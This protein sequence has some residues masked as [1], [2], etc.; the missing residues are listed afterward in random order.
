M[1]LYE[2]LISQAPDI[3]CV[4]A[5]TK[6]R[7]KARWNNNA[8]IEDD[9]KDPD[10]GNA[11]PSVFEIITAWNQVK[12]EQVAAALVVS[13]EKQK[14][15]QYSAWVALGFNAG[16]YKLRVSDGDQVAFSKLMSSLMFKNPSD[17]FEVKI[18]AMDG[19]IKTLTYAQFKTL[20]IAY[21]DYCYTY[22]KAGKGIQ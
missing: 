15:A 18:E 21:G 6:I 1:N 4:L 12:T 8:L 10:N 19:S 9:F 11:L 22:W 17:D 20:M 7:P 13:A 3:D 5:I 16:G 2:Q 14:E